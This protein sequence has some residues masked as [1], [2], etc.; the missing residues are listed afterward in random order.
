[1]RSL[2][3]S[4]FFPIYIYIHLHAHCEAEAVGKK[5][6]LSSYSFPCAICLSLSLRYDFSSEWRVLLELN[7]SQFLNGHAM[8]P[9]LYTSLLLQPLQ[10]HNTTRQRVHIIFFFF[11]L[12]HFILRC[13]HFS[14]LRLYN[15]CDNHSLQRVNGSTRYFIFSTE[16]SPPCGLRIAWKRVRQPYMPTIE[17]SIRFHF[18]KIFNSLFFSICK[19]IN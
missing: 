8:L 17:S 7:L 19:T 14:T 6:S 15:H 2:C 16:I 18:R 10:L 5:L 9:F 13:C 12:F 1:M 11:F 3:L 4:F